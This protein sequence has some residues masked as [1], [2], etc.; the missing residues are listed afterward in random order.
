MYLPYYM[1]N[2]HVCLIMSRFT[3][4]GNSESRLITLHEFENIFYNN[5]YKYKF[6]DMTSNFT[7]PCT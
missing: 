2:I 7:L 3:C 5:N 6:S 4:Y 1:Y